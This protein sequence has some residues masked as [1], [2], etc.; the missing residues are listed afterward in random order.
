MKVQLIAITQYLAGNGGTEELIEH[1]G[2]VCYRSESRGNPAAFLRAR[3]REGHESIIEHASASFEISGISR[4]CSHQL[5]RHRLASFSQ[6]SQRYVAMSDPAIVV[7]DEIRDN[8]EAQALW[9]GFID[10]VKTVYTEL[11]ARG[12]RKEDARFVLP[13]AAATRLVLTMNFRELRHFFRIR[14]A[15]E[16]QWE[17]RRMAVAML[18]EL[19]PHAPTVFGDLLDEM[20]ATHPEFFQT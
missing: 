4:A 9:D 15:P 2:R 18:T 11:R 19:V 12:I 6:E 3:L 16:A 13:N 5:V 8:P 1:A 17:I 7:P 10:Q 14:I 20:S